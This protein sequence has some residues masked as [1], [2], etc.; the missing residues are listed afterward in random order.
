MGL[1]GP[2]TNYWD[3]KLLLIPEKNHVQSTLMYNDLKNLMSI[4]QHGFMKIRSTITNLLQYHLLCWIQYW[5]Q[6]LAWFH[7]NG[8]FK[9]FMI[10]CVINCCWMR[11]LGVSSPQDACGWDI[12]Y[13]SL[14][15]IQKIRIGD[16]V[17][18]DIKV[19]SH[20]VF[21]REVIWDHFASSGLSTEYRRFSITYAYFS[22]F[23]F[24]LLPQRW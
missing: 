22:F 3:P 2:K 4:N 6:Q 10:V 24:P 18:N 13:L 8:F 21:H 16:A 1:L 17:S 15:R 7:L 19:T 12:Y 14:G 23:L 5:G 20:R 11:C 9:G